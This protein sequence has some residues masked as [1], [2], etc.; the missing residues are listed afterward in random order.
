MDRENR[1]TGV[2]T[3]HRSGILYNK[4]IWDLSNFSLQP[5]GRPQREAVVIPDDQE[6]HIGAESNGI[7]L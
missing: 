5:L 1:L 4:D 6:E 3:L 7:D 2:N